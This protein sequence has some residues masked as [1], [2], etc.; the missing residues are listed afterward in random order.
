MRESLAETLIGVL[1]LIVAGAF[2][3]FAV[4][5]SDSGISSG[6][7]YDVTA[8]F[9][10]V[11]GISRGSEVRM[12]GVKIGLVKAISL[13]FDRA[14][15][16]LT[17]SIDQRLELA[18]DADA[19]ISTDGLLGGAYIAVEQGGFPDPI[20]QDGT[21]EIEYTRGAV[22]LLTLV[23]SAVSGFNDDGDEGAAIP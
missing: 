5:S 12:A 14:D 11:S 13:D 22:D 20:P 6:D 23:G 16:V 18:E 3:T 2:V 9:N 7:S 15:A 10:N 4:S 17:L 8:R 21:G 1:V 19:R